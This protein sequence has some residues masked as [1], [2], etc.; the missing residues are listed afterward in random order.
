MQRSII[1][2][3]C[4]KAMSIITDPQS[5][6]IICGSCGL[7]V[8]DK[9]PV[10]GREWGTFT[11]DGRTG[12]PSSLARYDMGLSTIIGW[13]NK[14]SS[15][16]RLDEAMHSRIK[17]LRTWDSRIHLHTSVEKSLKQAFNELDSLKDKLGLS[18]VIVEKTAYLY[19]KAEQRALLRGRAISSILAAVVYIACR[20]MGMPRTLNEIAA[21]SNIKLRALAMD[22]RLLVKK[23]D[24]KIQLVDPIIC[25]AKI[26]NKANLTEKTKRQ[27]MDIMHDVIKR[28]ISAGKRPMAL[29]ASVI[30]LSA[31]NTG[32]NKTQRDIAQAAGVSE[33]ALRIR[34]QDLKNRLD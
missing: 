4:N 15:G 34:I 26:A 14:D 30:Y 16:H 22:Y 18:D 32:E 11:A 31:M 23:L 21:S 12:L 7:V 10:R 25:I 1:C 3:A 6:E 17:R 27:A 24:L 9:I 29:A 33:F 28:E 19:R 13:T 5:G 2:S 20:E 8:L